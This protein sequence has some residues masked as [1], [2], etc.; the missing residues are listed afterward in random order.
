MRHAGALAASA[1][2]TAAVTAGGVLVASQEGLLGFDRPAP[3]VSQAPGPAPSGPATPVRS[4]LPGP[5]KADP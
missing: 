4:G 5:S 1:A 3:A 2:I